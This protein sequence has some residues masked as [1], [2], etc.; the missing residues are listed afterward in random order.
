[1]YGIMHN[2][3]DFAEHIQEQNKANSGDNVNKLSQNL[4]K[5]PEFA[6]DLYIAPEYCRILYK[7][8]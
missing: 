1:M 7:Y 5:F 4:H 3:N 2:G 6:L 8:I